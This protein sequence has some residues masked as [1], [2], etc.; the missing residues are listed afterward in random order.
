MATV[1]EMAE[2]FTRLVNEGH[3]DV[4]VYTM[5]CSTGVTDYCE[6]GSLTQ[7]NHEEQDGSV[8]DVP[9]GTPVVFLYI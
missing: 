1:A 2:Y 7:V 9:E 5:Q 3:E 6:T 4:E 8:T